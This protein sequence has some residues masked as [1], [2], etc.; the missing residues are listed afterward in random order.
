MTGILLRRRSCRRGGPEPQWVMAFGLRPGRWLHS[1]W[2]PLTRTSV[3][4]PL[5]RGLRGSLRLWLGPTSFLGLLL[6]Q[7]TRCREKDAR[8]AVVPLVARVLVDQLVDP[9]SGIT[10]VHG[11]VSVVGSVTVN[12]YSIVS[13]STRVKRSTRCVCGARAG[14]AR[15]TL[16]IDGLDDERVALPAAARVAGP[17]GELCRAGG[18]RAG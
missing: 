10:A 5:L 1:S 3:T 13:G 12:S 11:R 4:H 2:F 8:H 6:L 17:P 16:E 14:Q 15:L 9:L 7:E 18:R